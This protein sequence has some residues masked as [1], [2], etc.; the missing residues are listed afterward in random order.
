MNKTKILAYLHVA[1][2]TVLALEEI[3]ERLIDAIG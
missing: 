1:L 3:L 2:T